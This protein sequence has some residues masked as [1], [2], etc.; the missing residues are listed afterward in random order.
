MPVLI[1]DISVY[2]IRLIVSSKI[3]PLRTSDLEEQ[4][5]T[6]TWMYK[7]VL[8]TVAFPVYLYVSV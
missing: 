6:C 1:I 4:C 7:T 8:S 3:F 5:Y 2:T